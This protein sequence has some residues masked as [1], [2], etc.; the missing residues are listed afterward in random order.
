MIFKYS[1]LP[2]T[3]KL[4]VE[5]FEYRLPIHTEDTVMFILMQHVGMIIKASLAS[6]CAPR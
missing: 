3:N 5:D 1:N 6:I 2:I 4:E